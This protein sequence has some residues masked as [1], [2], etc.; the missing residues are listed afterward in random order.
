MRGNLYCCGMCM[1]A[2]GGHCSDC[3]GR[4]RDT[5]GNGV[6]HDSDSQSPH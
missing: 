1:A 3:H 5:G 2:A 4:A 6:I